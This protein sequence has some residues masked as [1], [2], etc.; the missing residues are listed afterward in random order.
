[1]WLIKKF[2]TKKMRSETGN[3]GPG[4]QSHFLLYGLEEI[5]N[6][7]SCNFFIHRKLIISS[8]SLARYDV[9]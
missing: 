1:M 5:T 3:L 4:S 6:S 7:L 2:G 8:D 9:K